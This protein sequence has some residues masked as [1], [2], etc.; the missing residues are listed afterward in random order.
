[1]D[2]TL[3]WDGLKAQMI[4][5][6]PNRPEFSDWRDFWKQI[7]PILESNFEDIFSKQKGPGG[8]WKE[9]NP[10]YKNWK[11]VSGYSTRKLQKTGRLKSSVTKKTADS[12]RKTSKRSMKYGVDA[13]KFPGNYP[14]V[15][16]E[17]A[18]F[19]VPVTKKSRKYFW[20]QYY[21]TGDS[22][23]KAM[24]LTP[25]KKFTIT[26]P[27]RPFMYLRDKQYEKIL[28]KSIDYLRKIQDKLRSAI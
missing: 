2:V 26:I 3:D 25:Q 12:I 14:A 10:M 20:A 16:Q 6:N 18:T 15:H 13:S 11:S 1:M 9:I 27:K 28:G 4:A 17:G 23:W 24:A 8:S 22:R 19:T 7:M 5:F 21:K